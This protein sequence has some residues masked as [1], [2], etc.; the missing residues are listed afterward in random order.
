VSGFLVES[1][2]PVRMKSSQAWL[3]GYLTLN[4]RADWQGL[5]E[6]T[7]QTSPV[8]LYCYHNT[9]VTEYLFGNFQTFHEHSY[10]K[11]FDTGGSSPF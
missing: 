5:G 1:S 3:R 4:S 9:N 8:E 6:R 2:I 7:G 10:T 11:P